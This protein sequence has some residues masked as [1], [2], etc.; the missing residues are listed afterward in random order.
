MLNSVRVSN[1]A[2]RFFKESIMNIAGLPLQGFGQM[3][4]QITGDKSFQNV[5]RDAAQ[6]AST[7]TQ[8]GGTENAVFNQL[9]NA[10][11][12]DQTTQQVGQFFHALVS[13]QDPIASGAQLI[14]NSGLLGGFSASQ[15]YRGGQQLVD[16]NIGGAENVLNAFGVNPLIGGF[17]PFDLIT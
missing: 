17:N 5:T 7:A 4:S 10:L 6:F 14:D 1:I 13:G 3:A 8:P 9:P 11:G 12:L 15:A 2:N 16:G